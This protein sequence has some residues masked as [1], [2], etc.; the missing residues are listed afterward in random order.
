MK[1]I[2]VFI[3]LLSGVSVF[4]VDFPNRNQQSTLTNSQY[5]GYSTVAT[6]GTTTMGDGSIIEGGYTPSAAPR[7]S[8]S[9]GDTYVDE[10]GNVYVWDGTDW[11][12]NTQLENAGS[13]TPIGDAI[14]PLLMCLALMV[15]FKLRFMKKA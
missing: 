7:R 3:L 14:L 13:P 2:L 6:G 9:I 8:S 1:K 4:A 10:N 12:A 15:C 11:V 5:G